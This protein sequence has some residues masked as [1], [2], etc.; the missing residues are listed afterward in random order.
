MDIEQAAGGQQLPDELHQSR[1]HARQLD[2]PGR[3]SHL[4]G[5]VAAKTK[6]RKGRPAHRG[7]VFLNI[8]S[9]VEDPV[10][11][12]AFKD[13]AHGALIILLVAGQYERA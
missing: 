6:P 3:A 1:R 9:Q 10:V 2:A 12:L 5:V 4:M 8:R 11:D 13:L 7:E